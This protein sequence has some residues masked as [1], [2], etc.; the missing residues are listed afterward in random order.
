MFLKTAELKKLMKDALKRSGLVV[1]Y[2]NQHYLVYTN[3]WGAYID[4][5]HASNKFKAAI[6]ELVGDLPEQGECYRYTI[7]NK[8]PEQENVMDYPN[9]YRLWMEA[10][11]PA[12]IT[13][14]GLMAWPHTYTVVQRKSDL[15]FLTVKNS[16][17]GNV[18]SESEL[19]KDESMPGRPNLL[20]ATLYF[21]NESGIWWA[22]TERAG[23]KVEEALFPQM[24]GL[25][26]FE[27]SWL[28]KK[29]E[30][31]KET[32]ETGKA[33]EEPLPY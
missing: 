1:G 2:V 17:V 15:A 3:T 24:E 5:L 12:A 16:L 23:H 21:K 8:I 10:K 26:F 9:P 13:P 19:E 22:A 30:A 32:E 18:I 11:D 14:M 31:G 6:M 28:V 27:D 25:D 20:G 7:K 33:D 4:D 29:E